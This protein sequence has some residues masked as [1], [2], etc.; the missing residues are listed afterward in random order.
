MDV[1]MVPVP[2]EKHDPNR[3]QMFQDADAAKFS[4]DRWFLGIFLHLY[5]TFLASTL[6]K[7]ARLSYWCRV[8]CHGA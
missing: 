8:P 1:T 5:V 2:L 3:Q 6:R 4:Q 7:C